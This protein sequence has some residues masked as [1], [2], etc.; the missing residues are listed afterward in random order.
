MKRITDAL[1]EK[2]REE[3][4]RVKVLKTFKS[5]LIQTIFG[6]SNPYNGELF[7]PMGRFLYPQYVSLTMNDVS[8]GV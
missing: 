6:S 5:R 2:D 8:G 1:E 4:A 3:Q 7:L